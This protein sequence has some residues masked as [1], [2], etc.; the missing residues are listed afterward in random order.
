[1]TPTQVNHLNIGLMVASMAAAF[2]LPFEV[3]LIS[4]AVL[5]PLHYLTE[6]SWLHDRGY[7]AI[8][9]SECVGLVLIA[10]LSVFASGHFPAITSAEVQS[11]S[12]EMSVAA[13][14]LALM[15]VVARKKW[16]RWTSLALLIGIV[17]Y[18]HQLRPKAFTGY[19][20]FF[21]IYLTTIIHVFVFTGAFVLYGALKSNSRSGLVSFWVFLACAAACLF[22]PAYSTPELSEDTV[23]AYKLTSQPLVGY[24]VYHLPFYD[25]LA[26]PDEVFQA[27][28]AIQV[29]RFV[30]WAYTYHYLNWFS[31]TSIIKW[32]E[33]P[34]SRFVVVVVIW[35]ASLALYAYEYI[36]GLRW[37]LLLSL[38]HVFMEFPLNW[39]SFFG[40]G[41][42][43]MARARRQVT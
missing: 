9:K 25:R 19:D 11:W 32:H 8:H 33:V 41:S 35:I 31:K 38:L 28:A 42:E 1:V 20:V 7:F 29:A 24:L 6:L 12:A 15:A 14:G 23:G 13:L 5:G 16:V 40:I 30:A 4:Y 27:P 34:R 17:L 3:F 37:L 18:A 10:L 22:A 39:R 2:V 36:E 43:L 26:H 21:S